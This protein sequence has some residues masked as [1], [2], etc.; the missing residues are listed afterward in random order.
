MKKILFFALMAA[1]VIGCKRS[2]ETP[3]VEDNGQL[4]RL[5]SGSVKLG[6]A[7]V[8]NQGVRVD[9]VLD[10]QIGV[11][12][13]NA[14][15]SAG[16]ETPDWTPS[17][18]VYFENAPALCTEVSELVNSKPASFSWGPQGEAN[19]THNKLYP[20]ADGKIFVYAYY[21]YTASADSINI[22]ATDG[23]SVSYT[24]NTTSPLEQPDILWAIGK[25]K[26]SEPFVYRKD[27]LNVLQF[28]H[29]LAQINFTLYKADEN[30]QAC[31]LVD[32]ELQVPSAGT[33]N[34]T[35]TSNN[36]TLETSTGTQTIG[37]YKIKATD[38]NIQNKA[39]EEWENKGAGDV[40]EVRPDAVLKSPYMIWPLT[41]TEA[42][43]CKL[44][45]TLY[46]GSGDPSTDPD[47]VKVFDID[48][49]KMSE[50]KQGKLNHFI[51]GVTP[52]VIDLKGQITEWDTTNGQD[53]ELDIE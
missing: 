12:A 30:T 50:I 7:D 23:P 4:I 13:A 2:P 43:S 53:S 19:V 10:D 8:A 16:S 22:D 39:V 11:F 49:A 24:L 15:G 21:P 31:E 46:F 52:T 44:K 1:A 34:L 38:T 36:V 37:T 5:S 42:Q 45:V 29:A 3:Q 51:L 28:E 20:K 27:P 47:N 18:G 25:S 9:F 41:A 6:R 33:I 40:S 14:T 32:I 17:I 26:Q 35:K 48:M